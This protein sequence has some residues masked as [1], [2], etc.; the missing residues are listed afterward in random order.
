MWFCGYLIPVGATDEVRFVWK[1][2]TY[3]VWDM[4]HN[5]I[6]RMMRMMVMMVMVMVMVLIV[7]MIVTM[8]RRRR[9]RRRKRMLTIT[10]DE[11]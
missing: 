5:L 3:F 6:M 9:R 1:G 8:R 10:G 7:M 4:V 2:H 11:V